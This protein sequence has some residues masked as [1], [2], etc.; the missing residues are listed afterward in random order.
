MRP[1]TNLA[2]AT[3]LS[4]VETEAVLKRLPQIKSETSDETEFAL[5][6]QSLPPPR[7]GVTVMQ[8]FPAANEVA[9]PDSTTAETLEVVRYSP[10][11]E[12]PI[13]PNLS[14]TFSQPMVAITSQEEAAKYVPVKL[15]PEPR[16]KMALDRNENPAVRT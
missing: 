5:R 1:A 16:W 2:P 11:G 10:E 3:S 15:A 7:T 14:V 8:P 12:V 9:P 13:A 4:N 6:M